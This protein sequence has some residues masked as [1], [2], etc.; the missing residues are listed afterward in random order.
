[1]V[2]MKEEDAS[3]LANRVEDLKEDETSELADL[4]NTYNQ[5]LK[6]ENY[7]DKRMWFYSELID[8]STDGY[9]ERRMRK[10][11]FE[12]LRG[13]YNQKKGQRQVRAP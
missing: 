9:R 11:A 2:A 8:R 6:E 5:R 1:M 10:Q 12:A 7:I 3:R 4:N 13:Y